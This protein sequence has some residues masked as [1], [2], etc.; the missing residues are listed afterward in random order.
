MPAFVDEQ[1]ESERHAEFGAT[2]GNGT[3]RFRHR[4]LRIGLVCAYRPGRFMPGCSSVCREWR[5][6]AGRVEEDRPSR[7]DSSACLLPNSR[8]Y[9]AIAYDVRDIQPDGTVGIAAHMM[10]QD[11]FTHSPMDWPLHFS[12]GSFAA[13]DA[14]HNPAVWRFD[15]R[16]LIAGDHRPCQM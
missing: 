10:Q 4:T 15:K 11:G 3:G 16:W 2:E 12:V 1:A 6:G 9:H 5:H 7:F 13:H 8:R 14:I